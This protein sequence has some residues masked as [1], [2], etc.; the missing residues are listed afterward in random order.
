[1]ND[2]SDMKNFTNISDIISITEFEKI[3]TFILTKGDR[4]FYRSFDSNNPHF[5]FTNFDVFMG[6]DIGQANI[7]NDPT[8]SDFNELTIVDRNADITYYHIVIV[9]KGDLKAQKAW[10]IKGMKEEQVYLVDVYSKGVELM[11]N[12]LPNYLKKIKKEIAI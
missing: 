6:A 2:T 4:M 8:I 1:M 3:K 7:N 9:R 11:L 10:I 5:K 12:N